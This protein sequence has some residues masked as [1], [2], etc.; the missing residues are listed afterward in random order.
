ML[1]RH[2]R[3]IFDSLPPSRLLVIGHE[4]IASIRNPNLPMNGYIEVIHVS[5]GYNSTMNSIMAH[6][7]AEIPSVKTASLRFNQPHRSQI[8]CQIL[9]NSHSSPFECFRSKVPGF[10]SIRIAH[11]RRK[12]FLFCSLC[13]VSERD[14]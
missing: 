10:S 1:N 5:W 8:C 14:R 2:E 12:A 13:I 7:P 4:T 6:D 11:H 9:S 3:I